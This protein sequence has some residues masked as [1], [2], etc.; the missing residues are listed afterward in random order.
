MDEREVSVAITDTTAT[1]I[2]GMVLAAAASMLL[3]AVI[4]WLARR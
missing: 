3:F 4:R 1:A 2:R